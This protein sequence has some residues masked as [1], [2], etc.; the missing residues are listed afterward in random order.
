[1]KYFRENQE[2]DNTDLKTTGAPQPARSPQSPI[3]LQPAP[4][5]RYCGK[6]ENS[7]QDE[8]KR[9]RMIIQN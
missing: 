4:L 2:L 8:T 6:S 3:P 9:G 1:M 7:S 5:S